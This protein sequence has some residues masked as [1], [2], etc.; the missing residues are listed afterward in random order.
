MQIF[1]KFENITLTISY[2]E[3]TGLQMS[4]K[5]SSEIKGWSAFQYCFKAEGVCLSFFSR[6]DFSL[7]TLYQIIT[8][9]P[10]FR[11]REREREREKKGSRNS[12]TSC[13]SVS[14]LHSIYSPHNSQLKKNSEGKRIYKERPV[15]TKLCRK[16]HVLHVQHMLK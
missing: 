11:E 10:Y 14:E 9:E 1:G 3:V 7:L 16:K 12:L 15:D 13:Q 5:T 2:K 6:L 8:V 4:G